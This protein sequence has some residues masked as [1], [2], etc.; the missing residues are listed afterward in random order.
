MGFFVLLKSF[1]AFKTSGTQ[2][3]LIGQR[4]VMARHVQPHLTIIAEAFTADVTFERG[5]AGMEPNVNLIAM[6]VSVSLVAIFA[7]QRRIQFVAL[8]V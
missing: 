5:L 2:I 7:D 1:W 3:A 6:P 8:F 4:T